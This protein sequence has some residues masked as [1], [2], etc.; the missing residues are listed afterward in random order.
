MM[1]NILSGVGAVTVIL[2]LAGMV[3]IGH[4]TF[5][6]GAKPMCEQGYKT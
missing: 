3:G 6:Y 5:Y 1:K 4:F 2:T